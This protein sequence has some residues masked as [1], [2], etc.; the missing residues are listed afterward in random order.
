MLKHIC[1]IYCT[2]Q[3][4]L[5][6]KLIYSRAM[7]PTTSEGY[8][9]AYGWAHI[10]RTEGPTWENPLPV[11]RGGAIKDYCTYII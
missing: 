5:Y 10:F 9:A 6:I 1:I 4:Y 8:S 7:A 11:H 3:I 2:L